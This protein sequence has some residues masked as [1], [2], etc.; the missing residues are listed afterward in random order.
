M[1]SLPP[2]RMASEVVTVVVVQYRSIPYFGQDVP[3]CE[4]GTGVPS[5]LGLVVGG[6]LEVLGRAQYFRHTA[7]CSLAPALVCSEV[8]TA[9]GDVYRVNMYTL[10]W[11]CH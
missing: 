11:P 9:T 8:D 6:L 2:R 7:P 10:Y 3:C 1:Q 5:N 4:A